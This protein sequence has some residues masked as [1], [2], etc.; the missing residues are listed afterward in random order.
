MQAS[1]DRRAARLA[2]AALVAVF[3][4]G[5]VWTAL[6]PPADAQNV[7]LGLRVYKEKANCALCHGWSGNGD[8]EMDNPAP[9]M[10]V[11]VLDRAGLVETIRC[12]RPSTNM[13]RHSRR[14]YTDD[15]ATS[16]YGVTEEEMGD[17]LPNPAPNFLS[18]REIEAVAD[19]VMAWV[20]GRDEKPTLEECVFYFGEGHVACSRFE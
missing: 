15:P 3:L 12:G 17:L 16:C 8:G 9:S 10:R 19:Y 2:G 4:G 6:P 13:A 14:A 18:D 7:S 20:L 11:A 5:L 1:R